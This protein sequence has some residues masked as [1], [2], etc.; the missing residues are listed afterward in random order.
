MET[1]CR[2]PVPTRRPGRLLRPHQAAGLDDAEIEMG[3]D[4]GLRLANL[5]DRGVAQQSGPDDS[6]EV[7]VSIGVRGGGQRQLDRWVALDD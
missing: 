7:T 3:D 2:L 5:R 4:A 1:V 6:Q